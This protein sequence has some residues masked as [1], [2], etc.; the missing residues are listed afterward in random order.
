MN[1]SVASEPMFSRKLGANA[2]GLTNH[3]PILL[4]QPNPGA[5]LTKASTT[6]L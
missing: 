4:L 3:D 1:T 5:R 6:G 2:G